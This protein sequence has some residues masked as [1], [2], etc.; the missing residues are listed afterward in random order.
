MTYLI[1]V[2]AAAFPERVDVLPALSSEQLMATE[3]V[4]IAAMISDTLRAAM[5][6]GNLLIDSALILQDLVRSAHTS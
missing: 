2:C 3:V 5:A 6:F 1:E 4:D